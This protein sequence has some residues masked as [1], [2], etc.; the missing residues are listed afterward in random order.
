MTVNISWVEAKLSDSK[1]S[2]LVTKLAKS[3]K[4]IETG[5]C[6]CG[7]GCGP[8]DKSQIKVGAKQG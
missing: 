6:G 2:S 7:C 8:A 3:K 1:V 5:Q 4:D